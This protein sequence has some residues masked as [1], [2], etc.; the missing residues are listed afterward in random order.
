MAQV[1]LEQAVSYYGITMP[2]IR[3]IG[4]EV[5]TRCFLNCGRHAETGD[6]A[7]AIQPDHPAKIWR[8]HEAGCGRGGNLVSLCDLMKPGDN[9]GGK[10]RGERFKAILRDL[11]GMAAGAP[12]PP[13]AIA[14]EEPAAVKMP[15]TPRRR[16]NPPLAES[17]NERARGL[18][19]LD[20]KFVTDP[21]TMS[22]KAASYFRHRPF[23][24]REMCR[25]WR[26]GYLPRDTGGDHAGGTMRGKIVYPL[27]GED[28]EVLTWFGRDPE[29]DGK[30]H[31]WVVGGKQGKEPEKHHFVMGFARGLELFG[32]HR[33]REEGTAEK[34]RRLG[35][36]VVQGPNDVIALDGLGVPAVGLCATTI[37]GEQVEK[38]GRFSA[39]SGHG[40]VTVML[41]CTEA[42]SLAARVIVVE[43]AQVCPVRLAWSE[44]MHG[45]LFKGWEVASLSAEEWR[46]IA[47][48]LGERSLERG[49]A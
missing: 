29:Y 5:R 8:C 38:V 32:Q 2:E 24:T 19:H 30:V 22:P 10:P 20:E 47:G 12:P 36:V 18:V 21:A 6:R 7:L 1:P 34:L 13:S 25:R 3:R 11:Q 14:A 4:T 49:D 9:A 33:L 41:D 17:D 27:L 40:A 45:G 26:M 16:G 35:L 44:T 15:A 37:T 48:F 39:E 23:L 31:E 46:T 28:A 42:G 43:L